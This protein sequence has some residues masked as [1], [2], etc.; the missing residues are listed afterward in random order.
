MRRFIPIL[1][2]IILTL[3]CFH[4]LAFT[5][6]II[7]R[8]DTYIYFYPYWAARDAALRVGH[9]PL[10]TP[11]IFM[12]APMLADIQ[13]GVLY[14]PNW[15]TVSLNTPDAIRISILLHEA[16]MALGAYLLARR[17]LKLNQW[18]AVLAAGLFAF[19]G[20]VGGHVEQIN[21]LQGLAWMPWAFWAFHAILTQ[22]TWRECLS[23]VPT[24]ALI[25]ALQTLCGHTQT[26]FITGIGLA[27]YAA[28]SSQKSF[29][30]FRGRHTHND[31]RSSPSP[32]PHN[33]ATSQASA[34]ERGLGGEVKRQG[35]FFQSGSAFLLL[36]LAAIGALLLSLPQFAPTLQLIGLSNRQDGLTQNGAT[37]FSLSP[38]VIGRSL[39]PNYDTP[40]FGEYIA[41]IG[42][43]GLGLALIGMIYTPRRQSLI[44]IVLAVIGV[45]LALGAYNP[46]YW[47]LA[48]LPGFNFF[49][50]P[51]RWMALFALAAALLAGLGLQALMDGKRPT[52][53]V[54]ALIVGVIVALT[55]LTFLTPYSP[56]AD[57]VPGLSAPT[58]KALL[59]WGAA[60]AAFL[61]LIAFNRARFTQRESEAPLPATKTSNHSAP[62]VGE[63]FGVRSE[64]QSQ[65]S[66]SAL[67][68]KDWGVWLIFAL[69][70]LE[71][72]LAAAAQPFN[73]LSAPDVYDSRRFP[74]NQ[75]QAFNAA[76][77]VPDRMLSFS[78]LVFDPGDRAALEARYVSLGMSESAIRNSFIDIKMNEILSPNQP[79]R[80]DIP[81]ADGFGGGLVPTAYYTWFASLITPDGRPAIDGRL[82]E[83]LA[84]PEE[85]RGGCIPDLRWLDLMSVRYL[86]V[87]KVY[88]FW[89]DGVAYDTAFEIA[90][91]D[92]SY[93]PL[94]PTN[95]EA[96]ALDVLYR[97][98]S[99]P[100]LIIN[101]ETIAGETLRA[102][103]PTAPSL[104]NFQLVRF[105]F[106]PRS[107][108]FG[109]LQAN[110]DTLIRALTLVDTRTPEV[111]QQVTV[112]NHWRLTLSSDVKIYERVEP[113]PRAF[114]VREIITVPDDDGSVNAALQIMDT[115]DFD[116]ATTAVIA[117]DNLPTADSTPLDSTVTITRY[118]AEH[119]ELQVN[120]SRAGYLVLA[121]AWYPGWH[122]T[123][124]GVETPVYRADVMF[125]SIHIPEGDSTITFTFSPTAYPVALYIGGAAWLALFIFV[126]FITWRKFRSS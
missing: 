39:L 62:A 27:I 76:A 89:Q 25:M 54:L 72:I 112:D 51:A 113:A 93:T 40:L 22:S 74:V 86:I 16:W 31:E 117:A 80:W 36:V 43:A 9:I 45:V 95:F 50:V 70:I 100:Q 119:I 115:P 60:L 13:V 24:L 67:F 123:I 35:F 32:L 99:A 19:G 49:R 4:K 59:A 104:E 1:A 103:D 94:Y 81:T 12:G 126:L 10:W 7:A 105:T 46:L 68:L 2:L 90:L 57:T 91:T 34:G 78:D 125:R 5:D 56:E 21:Q 47:A 61:T 114:M 65:N 26:V 121:E 11:N 63:G 48:T 38:F 88:D 77:I 28:I 122:A 17:A 98:D 84:F 20:H 69:A 118:E 55:A 124:N 3:L 106:D 14:P 102:L 101:G 58:P 42:I 82:R 6:G 85:C 41:Y 33:L 109:T 116:P 92:E 87:D 75:L 111:F 97:G 83:A 53:R 29:G 66:F 96:N 120:T 107:D 108:N 18:A 37:A 30:I 52:I 79:L 8:G 23:H 73:D 64:R 71:I 110:G 15:L 44:W